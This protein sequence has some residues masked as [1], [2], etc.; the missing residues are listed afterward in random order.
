[1]KLANL[2][3]WHITIGII[4]AL[5]IFLQAGSG[6]VISVN[7]LIK[8]LTPKKQMQVQAEKQKPDIIRAVTGFIHYGDGYIGK[9]YRILLMLGLLWLVISGSIIYYQTWLL[10]HK[11]KKPPV[12][13]E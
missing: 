4:L 13:K 10:T 8:M 5:F 7:G 6:L 2:R 9:F 11:K 1:M 12:H 3:K